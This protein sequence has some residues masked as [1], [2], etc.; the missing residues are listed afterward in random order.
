[1]TIPTNSVLEIGAGTRLVYLGGGKA[2]LER[3]YPE[4]GPTG[5]L[6]NSGKGIWKTDAEYYP[7]HINMQLTET[8]IKLWESKL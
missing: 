5:G 4:R 6:T 1:M 2:N 8:Q 7:Q 3:F